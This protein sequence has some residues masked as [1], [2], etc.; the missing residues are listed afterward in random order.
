[1]VRRMP[2]KDPDPYGA[3]SQYIARRRGLCPHL[4]QHRDRDPSATIMMARGPGRIA[5][6]PR[7][8]RHYGAV[9]RIDDDGDAII[10]FDGVRPNAQM[11]FKENFDKFNTEQGTE[12]PDDEHLN[13]MLYPDL[14]VLASVQGLR[15]VDLHDAASA[16]QALRR[17]RGRSREPKPQPMHTDG[18]NEAP[19]HSA[20][21]VE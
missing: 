4:A 20:G 1:M 3:I 8:R 10:F 11:I 14:V 21:G 13:A 2:Y 5:A 19:L 6:H 17:H 16:R 9:K 7:H 12:I 18:Q 15:V